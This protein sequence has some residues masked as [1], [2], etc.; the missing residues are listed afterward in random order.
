MENIRRL[1]ESAA[2]KLEAAQARYKANFDKKVRLLKPPKVGDM[3]YVSRESGIAGEANGIKH[4][5]KL[6]QKAY[7]PFEVIS[8]TPHTLK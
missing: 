7:G 5:Q 1:S 6:Q 8:I 3:V 4:R 2:P